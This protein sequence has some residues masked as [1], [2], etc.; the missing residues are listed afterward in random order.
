MKQ[1]EILLALLV[2]FFDCSFANEEKTL[3]VLS[4]DNQ[5]QFGI[6]DPIS[7]CGMECLLFLQRTILANIIWQIITFVFF[8]CHCQVG[9]EL[10]VN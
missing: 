4:P 10:C 3:L 8:L 6:V 5:D 9:L 7:R 1:Q 2:L